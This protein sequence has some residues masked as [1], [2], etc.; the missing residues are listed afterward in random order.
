[1]FAPYAVTARRCRRDWDGAIQYRRHRASRPQREGGVGARERPLF[2][3]VIFQRPINHTEERSAMS[4]SAEP[5]HLN[6]HHRD[7]LLQ[8]FQHPT[9]HNIQWQAVVSLLEAVG[10]VE[11]RH[12]GKFLMRIGGDT[13]VI[14]RPKD[15]DIEI[16]LVLDLRRML[17]AAGYDAVVAQMEAK[18]KEV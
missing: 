5:V 16:E 11:P 8:I 1:V 13:E 17:T 9:S 12:D 10:T 2:C 18:G 7:T 3:I 6:N 15:K 4:S 14:E